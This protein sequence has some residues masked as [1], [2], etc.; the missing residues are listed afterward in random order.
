M[1]GD[2]GEIT[3]DLQSQARVLSDGDCAYMKYML[4][5]VF[6]CSCLNPALYL[7]IW[8]FLEVL[9]SSSNK[10]SCSRHGSSQHSSRERKSNEW[11][12][13]WV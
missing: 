13:R 5:A 2:A 1:R 7:F 3:R 6:G 10:S 9:V 8:K 12:T 4:S 11:R